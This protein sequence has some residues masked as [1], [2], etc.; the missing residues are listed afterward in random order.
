M[1]EVINLTKVYGDRTVVKALNF[2]IEPGKIY[3]FLGPNGAGKST[4]MNMLT[5]CLAPTEGKVLINGVDLA[6]DPV[7]AKRAIGYLPENPPL[8]T[9]MTIEEYLLF[10]GEAKGVSPRPA[11]F[12]QVYEAMEETNLLDHR[13]RLI[14]TLSKGYRQRV[15][16]AQAMLGNPQM[17]ILDE[18]TVGLDPRQIN[19]IRDLILSLGRTRT[20]LLS[21]HILSEISAVCDQ[22]LLMN[23]GRLVA[24]DTLENIRRSG[25][26]GNHIEL[27]VRATSAVVRPILDAMPE[28]AGYDITE[29]ED[30]PSLMH[31]SLDA[32]EDSD[33]RET[34]YFAFSERRLPLLRLNKVEP[35]LEEV[36]LRL[37]EATYEDE[38]YED[39]VDE[40][41]DEEE[42]EDEYEDD[43]DGDDEFDEDDPDDDYDEDVDDDYEDEEE[44]P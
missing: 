16:I 4:T 20:V 28:V 35:S 43:P 8:Y 9:D 7:T 19:D 3:G 30:D 6:E 34:L 12:D 23:H 27:T 10:I 15:G 26:R 41:D 25:S 14:Q 18:P 13:N 37:T 21:S 39:D 40:E 17:I 11:L 32:D 36:F 29:D 2:K 38:E 22:V 24:A 31:I 5:G 1:I 33:L 42:Y 44:Q